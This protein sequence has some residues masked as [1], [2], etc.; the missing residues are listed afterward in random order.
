M[1]IEKPLIMNLLLNGT[2]F[3]LP[4][5]RRWIHKDILAVF[6]MPIASARENGIIS[7]NLGLTMT[8]LPINESL[9]FELILIDDYNSSPAKDTKK[10]DT[11]LISSIVY[12]FQRI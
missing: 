9:S 11:S 10:N 12:T 8:D 4:Q 5:I 7:I 6:V 3:I 1:W 2:I